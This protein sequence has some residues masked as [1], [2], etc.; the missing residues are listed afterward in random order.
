MVVEGENIEINDSN[1]NTSNDDDDLY[2]KLYDD[3]IKIKKNVSLPKKT[4][5]TLEIDIKALQIKNVSNV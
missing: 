1:S 2:N 3:L 5:V 4:I